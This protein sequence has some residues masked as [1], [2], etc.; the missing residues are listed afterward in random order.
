MWH[1]EP[2]WQRLTAGT[3]SSTVGV[4]RAGDRVVKRLGAPLPGDPEM[5]SDPRHVAYWRRAADVALERTRRGHPGPALAGGARGRGGRRRHHGVAAAGARAA[6]DRTLRGPLPGRVRRAD[7]GSPD[8][9]GP[10]PAARPPADGRAPRRLADAGADHGRRRRRPPLAARGTSIWTRSTRCRW[11]R[12][13]ATRRPA[14]LH[15]HDE[16]G[17]LA[18]D[19]ATLGTGPVGGD[20]GY[21]SLS[22]REG[23]E[24]LVDAYV[25]G[26][27]GG[28]ASP[29]RCCSAPG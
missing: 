6:A 25:A 2:G 22:A 1:P 23:F 26:L 11:C 24:P 20:V 5:L 28:L 8:V 3:G 9:A 19:W 21:W 12:S 27:P 10:R 13:T 16:R 7:L 15:A 4:W 17:V 14:N 29:S 18:L